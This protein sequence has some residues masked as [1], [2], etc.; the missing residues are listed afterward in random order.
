MF[1]CLGLRHAELVDEF[2][3]GRFPIGEQA[4]DVASARIANCVEHVGRR[5][6]AGHPR[7]LHTDMDMCQDASATGPIAAEAGC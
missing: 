5:P 4:E 7:T 2:S 6:L 1:R 3:D